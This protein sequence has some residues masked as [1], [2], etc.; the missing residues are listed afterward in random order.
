MPIHYDHHT[1]IVEMNIVNGYPLYIYE[2]KI[3]LENNQSI[4]IH[5]DAYLNI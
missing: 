3:Q 5:L 2:N 1:C 4:S